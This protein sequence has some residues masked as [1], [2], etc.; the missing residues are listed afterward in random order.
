MVARF[1]AVPIA[2]ERPMV[3]EHIHGAAT[4][5]GVSDTAFPHRRR[6]PTRLVVSEW[7]E[8]SRQRAELLRGRGNRMMPCGLTSRQGAT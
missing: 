2:D 8:P 3:L 5:V 4:R 1:A 7:L 6:L